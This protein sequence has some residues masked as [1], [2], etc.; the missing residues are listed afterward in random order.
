MKKFVTILLVAMLA[1]SCVF[2]LTACEEKYSDEVLADSEN[3]YQITGAFNGWKVNTDPEDPTKLDAQYTMTAVALTNEVL[4]DIRKDLRD[5][6]GGAK[7]V[8]IAEHT[9][10][11]NKN[12]DGTW[13]AGW[14]VAYALEEGADV[15]EWDGNMALKVLRVKYSE[16]GEDY[17]IDS[18]L[19]FPAAIGFRSLTPSTVYIPPRSEEPAWENSGAWN[20][21]PVALEA[22]DY[23]VVFAVFNDGS[24]G[25]GLIAK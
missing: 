13:E 23:Y 3:S 22:G 25:L 10:T 2:V 14:N 19:P 7:F 5:S 17:T 24:F 8:Y 12:E 21:N 9:F 18:W 1:V 4:K 6:N 15:T 20:D 16:E 11:N